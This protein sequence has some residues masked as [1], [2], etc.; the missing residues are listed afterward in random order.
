MPGAY[1]WKANYCSSPGPDLRPGLEEMTSSAVHDEICRHTLNVCPF[2]GRTREGRP[3]GVRCGSSLSEDNQILTWQEGLQ[4]D[5]LGG[6]L[7]P[8]LTLG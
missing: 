2:P 6:L 7:A 4:Q 5:P 8:R 1:L 3:R